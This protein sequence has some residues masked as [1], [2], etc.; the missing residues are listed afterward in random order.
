MDL[1]VMLDLD[2]RE[3]FFEYLLVP[4][5]PEVK[6]STGALPSRLEVPEGN[7]STVSRAL[8]KI[9]QLRSATQSTVS[10]PHTAYHAPYSPAALDPTRC[11]VT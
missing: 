11:M 7:A 3:S 5:A 10:A 8:G 2:S 9:Q 1:K 4:P 6:A